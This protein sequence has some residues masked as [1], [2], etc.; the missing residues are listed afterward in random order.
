MW[1]RSSARSAAVAAAALA[2][3][4]C[5]RRP[6]EADPAE[7]QALALRIGK[8]VP[9]P[10]AARTCQPSELVGGATMTELTLRQLAKAEPSNEPTHGE[11]INPIELDSPAAIVL[12]DPASSAQVQRRAAAELLAAPFYLIYRI[13][14]IAAPLALGVKEYKRG[15]VGARALRYDKHG[16]LVCL[17]VFDWLNDDTVSRQ[18]FELAQRGQYGEKV[19]TLVRDD[20]RAQMLKKVGSLALPA[21][22][23][24]PRAP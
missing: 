2:L 23:P 20:L 10:G 4:A 13:D 11:W 9:V 6:P 16:K 21:P 8:N 3:A 22:A 5:A 19:I 14:H 1:G 12:I 17:V 18:A 15:S 7:I 24:A